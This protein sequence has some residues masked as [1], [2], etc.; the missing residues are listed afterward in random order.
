MLHVNKKY[1]HDYHWTGLVDGLHRLDKT[2]AGWTRLL[3][4]R[5]LLVGTALLTLC[6]ILL[7]LCATIL[8]AILQRLARPLRYRLVSR[9]P[10]PQA[11][12]APRPT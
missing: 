3:L 9:P 7:T 11:P 8:L 2:T 6:A 4:A 1:C 12:L 5:V 10:C